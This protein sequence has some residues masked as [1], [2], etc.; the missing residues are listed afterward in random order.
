MKTDDLGKK[1]DIEA[2][3][4]IPWFKII[5]IFSFIYFSIECELIYFDF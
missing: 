1:K 4:N 2:R 3:K 5:Y